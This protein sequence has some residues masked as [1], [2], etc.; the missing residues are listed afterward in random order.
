MFRWSE[1]WIWNHLTT[2]VRASRFS[3]VYSN[4]VMN[5]SCQLET[6]FLVPTTRVPIYSG[7]EMKRILQTP[8]EPLNSYA[9]EMDEINNQGPKKLHQKNW[10]NFNHQDS[11]VMS[12]SRDRLNWTQK[13]KSRSRCFWCIEMLNKRCRTHFKSF[14]E[15]PIVSRTQCCTEF[16]TSTLNSSFWKGA[17]VQ[18]QI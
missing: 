8:P 7:G 15:N 13:F 4:I 5:K 2:A 14:V 1:T 9:K 6:I 17:T 16:V 10:T 12:T 11:V 18:P 3:S